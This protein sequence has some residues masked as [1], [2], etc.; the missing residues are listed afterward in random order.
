LS[1][2]DTITRHYENQ[3]QKTSKEI[4]AQLDRLNPYLS[5]LETLSQKALKVSTSVHGLDCVLLGMRRISYVEDAFAA[6][7]KADIKDTAGLLRSLNAKK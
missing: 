2:L 3:A 1:F 6:I 4:A 7:L 5:K